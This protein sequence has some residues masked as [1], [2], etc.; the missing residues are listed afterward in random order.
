MTQIITLYEPPEGTPWYFVLFHI[1]LFLFAL[2]LPFLIRYVVLRRP[3][4][5]LLSAIPLALICGFFIAVNSYIL[6]P[7]NPSIGRDNASLVATCLLIA[8][9]IYSYCI[10]HTGYIDYCIKKLIADETDKK[11]KDDQK[12]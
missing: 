7:I 2:L 6:F 5:N 10:M 11:L 1:L 12:Q 4:I 8:F 9:C 3:V